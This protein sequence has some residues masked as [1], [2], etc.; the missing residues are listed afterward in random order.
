[1]PKYISVIMI[2]EVI[3]KKYGTGG[4][5]PIKQKYRTY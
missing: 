1:M 2:R 3:I 4:V 5:I